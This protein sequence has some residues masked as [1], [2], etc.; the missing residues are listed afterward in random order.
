MSG[1]HFR[2][3]HPIGPFIADFACIKAKLIIELDGNSHDNR[4][5]YDANR[6]FVLREWGWKTLRFPNVYARDKPDDLWREVEAQLRSGF[7]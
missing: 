4:Q 3:Q 5:D 1:F 6:D 2:R 7:H